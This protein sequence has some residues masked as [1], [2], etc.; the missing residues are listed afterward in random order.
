MDDLNKFRRFFNPSFWR[1]FQGK[2]NLFKVPTTGFKRTDFINQLHSDIVERRYY[3]SVPHVY[4]YYNKGGGVTRIVPAFEIR[5]YCVYYYCIKKLEDKI[6]INRVENTFGGWTFG[7]LMRRSEDEEMSRRKSNYDKQE[8][9]AE[10]VGVSVPQYSFNPA[11]WVRAYGD[12]N[13]KLFATAT[14]IDYRYV[15]EFDIANYYDSIRLDILENRIREVCEESLAVVISVLFHFLNYWNRKSNLY[16]RQ[17]VGLPQD[18]MGDCSRIL[19]NFYLQNYDRAISDFC[20]KHACKFLRYADDQF[21]FAKDKISLEKALFEASKQLNSIGLSINQKKVAIM[22]TGDLIVSRSFRVFD[23]LKDDSDRRDK[24]KVEE[25]VDLYLGFY[26]SKALE[27]LHKGGVSLLNRALACPA[28]RHI[29]PKKK[30]RLIAIAADATYLQNTSAIYLNKIYKL[31]PYKQ[32]AKFIRKIN[33]LANRLIHNGF[34][35]EALQ[36]YQ[37]N[38]INRA[39]LVARLKELEKDS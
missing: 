15:A 4:L 12:L 28:L 2:Q 25:F 20:N 33:K 35:Y 7:G 11:A 26:D 5:D 24:S 3:P 34:H 32:R 18:A 27:K 8:E 10:F 16:N 39:K 1:F 30:A 29:N 13:A 9:I 14:E 22:T 17:S 37:M 31:I 19:A 21:I 23:I 38:G 6:A 36:F